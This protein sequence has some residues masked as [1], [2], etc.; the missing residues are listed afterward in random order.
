MIHMRVALVVEWPARKRV[1]RWSLS[2]TEDIRL[3]YIGALVLI[4]KKPSTSLSL[5]FDAVFSDV[6][7]STSSRSS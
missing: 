5:S 6:Q 3:S 7:S 2:D 4:D 1:I